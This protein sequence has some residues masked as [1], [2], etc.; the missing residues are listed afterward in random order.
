MQLIIDGE[1]K[2]AGSG[3]SGGIL[4]LIIDVIFYLFLSPRRVWYLVAGVMSVFSSPLKAQSLVMC[5]SRGRHL[6]NIPRS[7][8]D[9]NSVVN[10]TGKLSIF[11]KCEKG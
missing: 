5:P 2:L 4:Y 6:I 10:G 1:H 11:L 8:E 3:V 7:M 9:D